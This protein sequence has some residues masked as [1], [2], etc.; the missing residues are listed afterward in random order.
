MAKEKINLGE[1]KE[2]KK[3]V[4][5]E[6]DI[7]PWVN[8]EEEEKEKQKLLEK[9][10]KE[11]ELN[12]ST[13]KNIERF[14]NKD[15]EEE[16]VSFAKKWFE[17]NKKSLEKQGISSDISEDKKVSIAVERGALDELKKDDK[18]KEVYQRTENL[19]V[20]KMELGKKKIPIESQ[21]LILNNL[22]KKADKINEEIEK[23]KEENEKSG[24]KE[25]K[26]LIKEKE[27]E[28]LFKA[29]KELAEKATDRDLEKEAK[30]EIKKSGD[31]KS[32]EEYVEDDGNIQQLKE[33][34]IEGAKKEI[35]KEKWESLDEKEKKK[36]I[37]KHGEEK[38]YS[39][40]IEDEIK[41]EKKSASEKRIEGLT[42]ENILILKLKGYNPEEFKKKGFIGKKI[43]VKEGEEIKDFGEFLEEQKEEFEKDLK[44]ELG[45]MWNSKYREDISKKT[46]EKIK[47]LAKSPERA[48][49]GIEGVY[50]KV[51][52]R[53]ILE[54]TEK[55]VSEEKSGEEIKKITETFG[56]KG[57]NTTDFI[58]DVILHEGELKNL[59]GDWSEDTESIAEFLGSYGIE[60][61]KKDLNKFVNPEE[62][63]KE[64][65]TQKGFFDF[66]W[67]LIKKILEQ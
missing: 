11:F 66:L 26:I 23:L 64:V 12:D 62:Y 65:K 43:E 56:E 4:K 32:R 9:Y 25:G 19:N 15:L 42:E 14:L 58:K 38:G 50:R 61:N 45:E 48:K 13:K 2:E 49:E 10:G 1:G 22:D 57:K 18:H 24:E 28:E 39:K 51:K 17:D 5:V 7:K 55:T 16:K 8:P 52:D 30:E 27:L 20:L 67:D 3:E 41:K 40:F 21:F 33:K 6:Q 59:E 37:K 35:F 31:Y 47:D 63:K 36:Y 53:L 44:E 34:K 46:E 60:T 29:R 54:Y